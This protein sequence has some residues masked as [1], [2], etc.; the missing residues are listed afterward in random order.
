MRIKSIALTDKGK[1]LSIAWYSGE[2]DNCLNTISGTEKPLPTFKEAWDA[3]AAAMWDVLSFP[4]P[5]DY[6]SG[7]YQ[8][9]KRTMRLQKMVFVKTDTE[10]GHF[11]KV[12]MELALCPWASM[13]DLMIMR[14]PPIYIKNT[15]TDDNPEECYS[16]GEASPALYKLIEAVKAEVERYIGGE[17][18]QP[19]IP[20]MEED[21][22]P[23]DMEAREVDMLAEAQAAD[24][25]A[26]DANAEKP[27]K[28]VNRK[29]K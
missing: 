21:A 8:R 22:E 12:R 29:K 13:T 24:Q 15:Y 2:E 4:M 3:L 7:R 10:K 6:S 27:I 1:K 20:G 23:A 19:S 16:A 18:L 11:E 17:R 25:A 26:D 28:V 5:P 14:V 9:P